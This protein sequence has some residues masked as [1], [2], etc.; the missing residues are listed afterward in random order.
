[1]AESP[2]REVGGEEVVPENDTKA[3]VQPPS[4]DGAEDRASPPR[5]KKEEGRRRR[6]R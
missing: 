5:T 3:E 4:T 2:D 6:S 1:M